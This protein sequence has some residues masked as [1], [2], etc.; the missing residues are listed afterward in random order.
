MNERIKELAKQAECT[1][2]S[3][4]FGEGNVEKFAEL[5]VKECVK[6]VEQWGQVLNL[7]PELLRVARSIKEH[8]GVK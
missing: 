3:M 6:D 7:E 2:D 1:I 5:I 8:F 4:G